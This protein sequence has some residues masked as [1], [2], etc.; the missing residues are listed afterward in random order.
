MKNRRQIILS[1]DGCLET[2]WPFMR[3]RFEQRLHQIATVKHIDTRKTSLTDID[4]N[5][6]DAIASFGGELTENI[7]ER[8]DQL[9]VVG[10]MT[11]GEG[12][13]SFDLLSEKNI[14]F[15]DATAAW[16]QS[17]AECGFGLILSALRMLPHWHKRLADGN[18]DWTYPYEQFCDD[19][20]FI[21][22]ELGTKTVGVVGLGQIGS[23]IATW[24]HQFGAT[25]LAYD[26]YV[27]DERF[28]KS[29]AT[30]KDLDTLINSA[31][32]L[33]IAVPPTPSAQNLVDAR[34]VQNLSK[35]SIV[36]T[37]TR[38]AAIDVNA[39]R[40]RVLANEILWA[41][42]VYDV[43]PLPANDPILGRDN[44]VH[45]PHIAGRT[46]DA[47]IRLADMLAD[48]FIRVFQ[49]ETP[50]FALTHKAVSIRTGRNS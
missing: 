11:D 5:G 37:I 47:N 35:G 38:T 46:K 41:S 26:P 14:P 1:D 10:G 33:V 20:N 32:I 28:E 43:E 19:P 29:G 13:S 31:E 4:W 18:F 49:G 9:K 2:S 16:G 50:A 23:R 3:E 30:K 21:N 44:V 12:P 34:L 45:T 39:L 25:V 40:E 24:S 7:I 6:I 42:D 15:I 8:A 36:I 27:P 22:G 48:D 17:V